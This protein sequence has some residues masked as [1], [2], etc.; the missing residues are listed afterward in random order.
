MKRFVLIILCV[1]AITSIMA[2]TTNTHNKFNHKDYQE[3]M[4]KFIIEEAGFSPKD[5]KDFFPIF[6]EMKEK[7]MKIGNK[8]KKLK[9]EPLDDDDDRNDDEEWAEA[10]IEIEELKVEQAQIG[11]AYIKRL[12]KVISGQKV[13]K[14]IKAEDAFHRHMLKNFRKEKR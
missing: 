1:F 6:H 12:C 2:Q 14:A 10:A 13:F 8:I 3:K 11:E 7:Q 4:E 5:A 9:R